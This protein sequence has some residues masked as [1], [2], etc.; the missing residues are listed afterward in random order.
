MDPVLSIIA[1]L[2]LL[3]A[4]HL[5]CDGPLQTAAMVAAKGRYGAPLGIVHAGIHG[6]A[7][8][9]ALLVWGAGPGIAIIIGLAESVVHY[10]IDFAKEQAGRR[11]ALTPRDRGFWWLLGADQALHRFTYLAIAAAV[12]LP[13]D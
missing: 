7:T 8:L 3:E 13:Q 5:L 2:A 10:H 9:L 12:G 4:K 1:L 6:L 11:L